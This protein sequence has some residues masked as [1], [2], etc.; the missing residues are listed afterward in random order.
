[1]L[2]ATGDYIFGQGASEFLVDIPAAVA[3]AVQTRLLLIQGEWYLDQDDGTPYYSL[4][5]GTGTQNTYDDAI[6]SRI[7]ETPGVVSIDEYSS[8]LNAQRQL[9]VTCTIT[10]QYG[11]ASVN[12]VLVVPPAYGALDSSFILDQSALS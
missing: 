3:Q 8:S 11:G 1:M 10:T 4:I 12:V 6:Q 9:T 7:L 2:S 5:L